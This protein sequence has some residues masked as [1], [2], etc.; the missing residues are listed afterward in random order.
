MIIKFK[1]IKIEAIVP[2]YALSGDAGMDIF[3]AEN[4]TLSPGER[5]GFS[6]GVAS[7]IPEGF[8]ILFAPKSGLALKD[9]IDVLA[10]VIDSGYRGEWIVILINFG[11]KQK[12]VKVGDKLAQ[13]ILQKVEPLEVRE[14][15]EL[16]K[17]ERGEGGFGSTGK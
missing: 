13:G 8:F 7:E 2:R 9:G 16:S 10:G 3:S 6:T 15:E 11:D 17:S 1:K 14:V 5:H 4:Y 12:E